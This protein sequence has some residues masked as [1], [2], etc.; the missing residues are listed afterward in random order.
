MPLRLARITELVWTKS[1]DL[2]AFAQTVFLGTFAKRVSLLN[3]GNQNVLY[4]FSRYT[5]IDECVTFPCLNLG[6]CV[7]RIDGYTC[8]C[9]DGYTGHSCETS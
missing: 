8:Y 5:D 2:R 1:T 9:M 7:D 4:S 3:D 6:T